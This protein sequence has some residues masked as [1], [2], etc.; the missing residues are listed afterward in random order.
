MFCSRSTIAFWDWDRIGVFKAGH[1]DRKKHYDEN[2][3]DGCLEAE[4]LSMEEVW[5]MR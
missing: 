1:E 4:T 3:K 2:L 5:E